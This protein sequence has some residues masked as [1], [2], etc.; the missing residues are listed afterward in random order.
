MGKKRTMGRRDANGKRIKWTEKEKQMVKALKA[1]GL[2]L[3]RPVLDLRGRAERLGKL[4]IINPARKPESDC[5][6]ARGL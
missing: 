3:N 1:Q 5:A 6:T 4:P 2:R